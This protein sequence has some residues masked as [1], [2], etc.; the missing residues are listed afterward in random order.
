MAVKKHRAPKK[1]YDLGP[2]PMV[3]TNDDEL[4]NA[5]QWYAYENTLKDGRRFFDEY[6]PEVFS[7]EEI[8][9]LNRLKD[10]EFTPTFFWQCRMMSNKV[11][12]KGLDE[13]FANKKV[14]LLALA[15]TKSDDE[16]KPTYTDNTKNQANFL[17]AEIDEIIDAEWVNPTGFEMS[18]FIIQHAMTKTAA[19]II[20]S[21]LKPQRDELKEALVG[22]DEQLNE[23]YRFAS[24][25]KITEVM[26]FYN[27][28][29]A[30]M[31]QFIKVVKVYVKKEKKT[32]EMVKDVKYMKTSSELNVVSID[33]EAIVGAKRVWVYNVKYKRL[34]ELIALDG[35]FEVRGT[36]IFNYDKKKS[37]AKFIKDPVEVLK[38]VQALEK[39]KLEKFM[40]KQTNTKMAASSF[41]NEDT[42]LVR[43]VR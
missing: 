30:D 3:I 14:E 38:S 40:S 29:I 7:A 26:R 33:P 21:R 37:V 12:F 19:G 35:G 18:K 31:E 24:K 16:T 28:M 15:E 32:S 6:A 10:H 43:V 23:G 39:G 9:K 22:T 41:L 2:E 34:G 4:I 11:E 5:Y 8:K 25:N 20:I 36:S 42:L 17:T 13:S 27:R 1:H